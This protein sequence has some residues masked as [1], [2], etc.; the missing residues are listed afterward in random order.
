MYLVSFVVKNLLKTSESKSPVNI[1][2]WTT[3]K[4][5]C[6]MLKRKMGFLFCFQPVYFHE[7]P[8][9]LRWTQWVTTRWL[10]M[11]WFAGGSAF[12]SISIFLFRFIGLPSPSWSLDVWLLS[13]GCPASCRRFFLNPEGHT[14]QIS[15]TRVFKMDF[16]LV[17]LRSRKGFLPSNM[18]AN[19]SLFP[20]QAR[21]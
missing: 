8:I 18:R 6:I 19:D 7:I 4:M 2:E 16:F 3:E 5:S 20:T 17:T 14:R 21:V 15:A 1:E 9:A 11:D 10:W 13:R 12:F